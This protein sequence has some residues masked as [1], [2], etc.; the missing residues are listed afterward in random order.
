MDLEIKNKVALVTGAGSGIGKATC[1]ELANEGCRI[2]AISRTK[3]DLKKLSL[4]IGTED[5]SF[6]T[7]DLSIKSEVIN[8]ISTLRDQNIHPD[9]VVNNVGGNLGVSNPLNTQSQFQDV[10]FLNLEVA[11]MINEFVIPSMIKKNWGRVCH[12][13][14]ISALENQGPP[15]Y[16]ASKA[17]LNAYVRSLGRFV[18]E[19]NVVLST[20]MPGAV[21][22]E[23]GYWSKAI[24]NRP[25]HVEKYLSERMSIKRFG[26]VKE[27]AK[28]IA[29]LCS[30]HASFIAG[31]GMVVDGG[32]GRV[33]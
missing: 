17:A 22:T 28:P 10:M 20:I 2:I 15:A 25:E 13:S 16:C 30:N 18:C 24:Q 19:H 23:N 26:K 3:S 7:S 9:I 8:V 1:V 31:T 6:V 14:S 33:F 32:Q 29:F 5:H 11:M 27:I 21:L 12:I 4:E